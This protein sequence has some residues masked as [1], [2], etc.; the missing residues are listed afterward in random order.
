M[1]D[2]QEESVDGYVV[3][4]FVGFTHAFH[5]V[6]TFYSVVTIQADCVVFEQN[7]DVG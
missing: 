7:G 2:G 3:A 1:A 6:H 5:H 4:F